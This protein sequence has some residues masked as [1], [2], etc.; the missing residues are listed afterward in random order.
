MSTVGQPNQ[1]SSNGYYRGVI[2]GVALTVAIVTVLNQITGSV[3]I[4]HAVPGATFSVDTSA[5]VKSVQ[6]VLVVSISF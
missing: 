3:S 1:K 5:S 6:I 2:V 4:S